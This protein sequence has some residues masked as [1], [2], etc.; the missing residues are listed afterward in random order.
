MLLDKGADI[1]SKNA[2]N[3]TPLYLA[4][5][6]ETENSENLEIVDM[7]MEHGADV[8]IWDID[9]LT[10]VMIAAEKGHMYVV[11]SLVKH[12]ARYVLISCSCCFDLSAGLTFKTKMTTTCSIFVLLLASRR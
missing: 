1:N 7:L 6:N 4:A 5:S 9:G 2:N 3:Q 11:Q 12:G 8:D 10:P